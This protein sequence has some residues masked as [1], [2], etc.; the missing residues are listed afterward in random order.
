MWLQRLA[1]DAMCLLCQPP[2]EQPGCAS[3]LWF[4]SRTPHL[5]APLSVA[6]AQGMSVV[7]ARFRRRPAR[8]ERR[9]K[10]QV[11]TLL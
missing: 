6:Y 4:K 5:S 2:L 7:G 8:N 9:G 3:W 11:K 1:H 10:G